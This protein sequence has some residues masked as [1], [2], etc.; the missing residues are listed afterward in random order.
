VADGGR[1]AAW[2]VEAGFGPS[3]LRHYRRGGLA[4][5]LSRDAYLWLGEARARSVAEFRCLQALRDAGLP[6]PAPIAACYRRRGGRYRAALL[7]QRIQP[8][9]SLAEC[10]LDEP[11]GGAWAATGQAIACLHRAGALHADLNAR[12]VLIDASGQAHV[13]DW[14]RGR[15]PVPG[16]A[17]RQRVLARLQ[18]SLR[19]ECAA[20]SDPVLEQGWRR[21][22]QAYSEAL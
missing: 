17:W 1:G 2:F 6:V 7:V 19:K 13:I 14:D 22:R 11:G 10:A 8:A 20:L 3:V 12:N 15:F 5:R 18:R 4:A 21:L 9:R 16:S